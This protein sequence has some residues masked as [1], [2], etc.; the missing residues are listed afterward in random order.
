MCDYR[1]QISY[2]VRRQHF[3]VIFA[4]YANKKGHQIAHAMAVQADK[5]LA[6]VVDQTVQKVG[7]DMVAS[8]SEGMDKGIQNLASNLT[9][10]TQT[11][12]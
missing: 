12:K 2:I 6:D 7:S 5:Q 10:S 3:L 1:Y 9:D 4:N 8:T 11:A